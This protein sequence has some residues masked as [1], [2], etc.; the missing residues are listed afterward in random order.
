MRPRF[1]V[2]IPAT[3][4]ARE[5][6]LISVTFRNRIFRSVAHDKIANRRRVYRRTRC[7]T[8]HDAHAHAGCIDA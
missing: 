2:A 1:P 6:I 5:I 4:A 7:Y 8:M 3:L